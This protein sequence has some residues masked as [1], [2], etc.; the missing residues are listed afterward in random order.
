[1]LPEGPRRIRQGDL[2]IKPANFTQRSNQ[3]LSITE[4]AEKNILQ[5]RFSELFTPVIEPE[6]MELAGQW[7]KSKKLV[8]KQ[9]TAE[10]GWLVMGWQQSKQFQQTITQTVEVNR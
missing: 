3:K 10:D 4:V 1:M 2:D 6:K 9:L 8:M 7:K 5:R